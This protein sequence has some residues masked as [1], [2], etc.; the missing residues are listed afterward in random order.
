MWISAGNFS[1]GVYAENSAGKDFVM[2]TLEVVSPSVE[3]TT[4]SPLNDATVGE[5]YSVMLDARGYNPSSEGT[6]VWSANGNL[7]DGLTLNENGNIY[8]TPATSGSFSF[9][10]T[11]KNG[12][13]SAEKS[14][15]I[16]V[17]S[18]QTYPPYI[19]TNSLP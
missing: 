16:N 13:Y 4:A 9:T 10:V 1:F 12:D 19:I 8:G 18:K 15:A 3:I 5:Y 17:I 14:F 2:F 7:P 11:V 6:W